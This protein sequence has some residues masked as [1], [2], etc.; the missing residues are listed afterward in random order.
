MKKQY[1][2]EFV[3]LSFRTVLSSFFRIYGKENTDERRPLRGIPGQDMEKSINM[4][5]T[6]FDKY[7]DIEEFKGNV[8]EHGNRLNAYRNA[9]KY[10]FISNLVG[11]KKAFDENV[12]KIRELE[13][14]LGSLT[15]EAVQGHSEE[16]IKKSKQKSSLATQKYNIES[17]IQAK[18]RKLQLIGMS[19]EYGLYPTEAD[20][21]SLQEFFPVV[22]IRKLYEVEK[23]HQKLAKILDGQ[24]ADEKISIE[25]EFQ[26]LQPQLTEV[27]HQ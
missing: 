2:I 5:L 12:V 8:T 15:E 6:L 17:M 26:G 25:Q 20:M 24:F 7:K 9:R 14:Q 4:L 23:Y 1:K 11:G 13:T 18:Q 3:G 27:R 21:S 10:E 16:D 22:I 19:L